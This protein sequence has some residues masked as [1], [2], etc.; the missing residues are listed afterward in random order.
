[1]NIDKLP[2]VLKAAY[3]FH[4]SVLLACPRISERLSRPVPVEMVR[5]LVE[6]FARQ[7]PEALVDSYQGIPR[8]FDPTRGFYRARRK[9]A[10][11][12][13]SMDGWDGSLPV[14]KEVM[15]AA[16]ELVAAYRHK[17]VDQ[18]EEYSI[19]GEFENALLWPES[20]DVPHGEEGLKA[21]AS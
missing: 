10:P 2:E 16:R 17:A 11:L 20:P 8:D 13:A 18:W 3:A 7:P 5:R 1:M 12:H 14:P 9:A 6:G 15:I 21:P 4:W 19:Q